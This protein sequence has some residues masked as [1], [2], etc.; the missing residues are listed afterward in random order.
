[1]DD[2]RIW[3][4]LG[5]STRRAILDL[6]RERPRTTGELAEQFIMSRYGVMKHLSVL[7]EAN[8][9]LVRRDGRVRWNHLNIVPLQE[10]IDRWAGPYQQQMARS[11]VTLKRIAE[12]GEGVMVKGVD[13][14][15][16]VARTIHIEQEIRIAAQ[17]ERVYD[18]LTGRVD[19]WW[20]AGYRLLQD[21]TVVMET[22]LGGRLYERDGKR[23]AMWASVTAL[24]P[25]RFLE[26]TGPIGMG[27][28]VIGLV[29]FELERLT[30]GTLVKLTHRA[31]GEVDEKTKSD[32]TGGWNYLIGTCLAG[33]VEES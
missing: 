9:V 2:E 5:D 13:D 18:A 31:A 6:L 4:A 26:L 1:V 22:H 14:G 25:G 24:E 23:E 28:A 17:P 15:V 16:A 32:Y 21:S 7:V 27:G 10:A 12:E 29:T 8:L 20:G 30:Q 3:K 11:L 33:L 19:E